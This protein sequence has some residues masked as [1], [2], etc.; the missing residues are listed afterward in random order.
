M[1]RH[2]FT[3]AARLLVGGCVGVAA[4]LP[5]GTPAQ[6]ATPNVWAFAAALNPTPV[7]GEVLAAA[8]QYGSFR[9]SCGTARARI[10]EPSV[11][12]YL[13]TFP[14]S[15]PTRGIAHVTAID[16]SRRHRTA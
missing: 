13:V 4:I 11:G 14:C 6:G 7:P 16:P 8:Y 5:A 2:G 15:A 3:L 10:S 9:A 12:G 1:R